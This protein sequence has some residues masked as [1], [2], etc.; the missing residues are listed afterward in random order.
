[1]KH[2]YHLVDISSWPLLISF[3]LLSFAINIISWIK[4]KELSITIFLSLLL[5]IYISYLWWRD[6]IRE[7]RKGDHT[8]KVQNG[9]LI[10]FLLFILSEIMLFFSLFWTFF[11]GSLSPAIEIGHTYPPLGIISMDYKTLPLLGSTLLLAS[12]FILTLSHHAIILGNKEITLIHLIFTILL[13]SFFLILQISE[14]KYAEFDFSDSVFG[15]IF[16]LTT[17]LHGLHVFVGVLFLFVALIRIYFDNFTSEHHLG[18]EFAIYY[19]HFVDIVWLF[20]YIT[21]YWWGM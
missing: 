18:Y 4:N 13:G 6:I 16:F 20:V 15:S 7:G 11:N 2:P 5:V 17:G 8:K 3:S 1:M 19:W 21:Y 9:L 12:G 10:G 14:Y